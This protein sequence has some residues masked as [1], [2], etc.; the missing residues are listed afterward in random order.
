MDAFDLSQAD[1]LLLD[2]Y[3]ASKSQRPELVRTSLLRARSEYQRLRRPAD[4]SKADV[5]LA[6]QLTRVQEREVAWARLLHD[7]GWSPPQP[8]SWV[9]ELTVDC[10]GGPHVITINADWTV[11][12]QLSEL[13]RREHVAEALVGSE[14]ECMKAGREVLRLKPWVT[15]RQRLA[16]TPEAWEEPRPLRWEMPRVRENGWAWGAVY[17][18]NTQYSVDDPSLW[19]FSRHPRPELFEAVLDGDPAPLPPEAEVL[20]AADCVGSR[21]AVLELWQVGVHPA[22][23]LAVHDSIGLDRPMPPL[24]VTQV[25]LRRAMRFDRFEHDQWVDDPL[26]VDLLVDLLGD[27]RGERRLRMCEFLVAAGGSRDSDD[28]SRLMGWL[29]QKD[30]PVQTRVL[31][32]RMGFDVADLSRWARDWGF[33]SPRHLAVAMQDTVPTRSKMPSSGDAA[34]GCWSRT[35][36]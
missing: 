19:G 11:T 9:D 29:A 22:L 23:V 36:L 26:P 18:D 17:A 8:V 20:R 5:L 13:Q 35:S 1:Q 3:D 6:Q 27:S 12:L 31:L 4:V 34:R 32:H 33:D 21:Q 28:P 15:C 2:A 14:L 30:L 24:V 16:P 10:T 25:V 7:V